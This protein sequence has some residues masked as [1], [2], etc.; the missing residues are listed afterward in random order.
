MRKER[1]ALKVSALSQNNGQLSWLPKNPRQWTQTDIDRTANSINEDEDFLEDRPLLVV[2]DGKKYV[3]FAGNL[4]LTAAKKEGLTEL[5]CVVYYPDTDDDHL[6][7]KRRA[8]K[9]NGSFGSWDFDALANEWDDLPLTDFGVPAWDPDAFGGYS[10]GEGGAPNSGRT[11]GKDDDYDPDQKVEER[12]KRGEIWA[13]GPHRLMCG[14]A[15]QMTNV[16]QLMGGSR[17][18]LWLTDP[19]YNVALGYEDSASEARQRHRRTDQKI[20]L[21]DK[22]PDEQ[23]REFLCRSYKTARDVMKEGAAYYIFHADN[24]SYNFRGAL[25]DVGGMQLRET[26][27]WV[28]DAL[29]L[30]RQ[31]YQWKHEPVLYGWKEGASH[32]WFSDRTQ[33]TCLEFQRP[34]RSEE[35]PTMKPIPLFVYLIQNSTKEGDIVLDSFGG[36]GTTI[37][38]CEQTGR[39]GYAMEL[40]E[41]YASVI[42]DRWEKF[43][44]KK[45]EKIA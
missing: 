37:I 33:T 16:E 36:S 32:Q 3:V 13:L 19:P 23:F 8:M 7:V 2:P 22:M 6:T 29:T 17:A 45:A 27:I 34:R 20:I 1:K 12:V 18:D 26:L 25:R 44:G 15:T 31:D 5:P 30:G 21:N 24:Q 10:S 35:H 41:H 4:R 39:I 14:D 38:A 11:E 42:V 40:D 43:T 28:K 9:D